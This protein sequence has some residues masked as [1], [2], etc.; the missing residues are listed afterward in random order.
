MP[1]AQLTAAPLGDDRFTAPPGEGDERRTYG[2]LIVGQALAAAAATADGVACHSLHLLFAGAGDGAQ[3]VAIAVDRLRDGRAFAARGVRV[4]QDGKLLANATLS[5]HRGDEGP[6][7][8]LAMPAAPGPESLEDQRE[9]RRRN[10]EA[11]GKTPRRSVAERLID[12]RPIELPLNQIE[13]G[14]EARRQLWFRSR[15]PLGDDVAAHQA[16]IAFAS[17]MGLVHL[18]MAAHN[19]SGDGG[20]LDAASLDHSVWFH[21]PARADDWLLYDQR[22]PVAH[23]GR[24]LTF[25][26][27][28]TRDGALVASVA[29][30]VL[31]RHAVR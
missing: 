20:Q 21:R 26:T 9:I 24:G 2:G 14:V 28:F 4:E 30:E 13:G 10:A 19:A 3:P 7:H 6:Q 31:I 8:Q 25:G 1:I 12:A 18:G 17:D 27:I 22:A 15:A 11:R 5:F 16:L 23:G 29:Q